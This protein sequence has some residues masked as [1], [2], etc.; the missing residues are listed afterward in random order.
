M[1]N[2][3]ENKIAKENENINK[4]DI[5]AVSLGSSIYIGSLGY[6]NDNNYLILAGLTLFSIGLFGLSKINWDRTLNNNK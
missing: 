1:G 6:Y 2:K 5:Y 4:R 3:L